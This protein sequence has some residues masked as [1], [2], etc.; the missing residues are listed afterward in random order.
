[1][2]KKRIKLLH[3]ISLT[4]LTLTLISPLAQYPLDEIGATYISILNA[5]KAGANTTLLT[6]QLDEIVD[7]TLN[8]G[9]S[10]DLGKL[11]DL[12]K[13]AGKLANLAHEEALWNSIILLLALIVSISLILALYYFLF[14]KGGI[15]KIWLKFRGGHILRVRKERVNRSS[16]LLDDEVRAV[17]AAILVIT[18]VF[19]AAQYINAG[20]VAE[21]FSELGILGKNKK[22]ADYP[23]NLT[24]GERALVYVYVGNQMGRPMFYEVEA[25]LGNKST[26]VDPSPATPFWH[27]Y[28][29]IEHNTSRIIPLSFSINETGRYRLIVELWAYNETIRNFQY[30]KRWVQLWIDVANP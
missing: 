29:I 10:I 17:L 14:K 18:L 9:K 23:T 5:N 13:E 26:E 11:E 12:R 3:Y 7:L 19:A 1:M 8:K 24:T 22:L 4:L 15:W 28:L 6:S 25:K 21:P 27:H 16:M 30:D 2:P 20:K